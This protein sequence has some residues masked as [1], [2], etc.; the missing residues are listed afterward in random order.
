[1]AVSAQVYFPAGRQ[2]IAAPWD[3]GHCQGC[4]VGSASTARRLNDHSYDSHGGFNRSP[5]ALKRRPG[6]A[7]PAGETSHRGLRLVLSGRLQGKGTGLTAAQPRKVCG[8]TLIAPS[9]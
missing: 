6:M 1:V 2:S 7:P 4:S 3:A 8:K 5:S 9:N